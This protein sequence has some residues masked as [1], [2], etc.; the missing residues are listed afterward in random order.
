M[1]KDKI[2]NIIE[3]DN[4]TDVVHISNLRSNWPSYFQLNL[5]NSIFEKK[6]YNNNF[7]TFNY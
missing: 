3:V 5:N 4:M 6:N 1:I 7:V 2:N